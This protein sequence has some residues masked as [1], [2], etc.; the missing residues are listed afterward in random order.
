[1]TAVDLVEWAIG[2]LYTTKL[3]KLLFK[4]TYY[5]IAGEQKGKSQRYLQAAL[6]T[7]KGYSEPKFPM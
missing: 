4:N 2:K 1:L 6:K 3:E 7:T 5:G